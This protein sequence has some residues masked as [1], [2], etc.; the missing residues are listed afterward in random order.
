MLC[1]FFFYFFKIFVLKCAHKRS[2]TYYFIRSSFL[3]QL[4]KVTMQSNFS[5]I[6]GKQKY[7]IES[8]SLEIQ[9]PSVKSKFA[10]WLHY[11]YN[12]LTKP[13]NIQQ[14]QIHICVKGGGGNPDTPPPQ[15]DPPMS[16]RN[17]FKR[18]GYRLCI[19]FGVKT[20]GKKTF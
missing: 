18:R 16:K 2:H 4:S 14:E 15:R 7:S 8:H 20:F 5:V 17:V 19:W 6:K 1:N 3:L 11:N 10:K 12:S 9:H 13:K